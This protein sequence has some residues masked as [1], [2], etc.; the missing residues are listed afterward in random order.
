M[1][2]SVGIGETPDA[3]AYG[4]E[5][6]NTISNTARAVGGLS[7][8]NMAS[9]GLTRIP[10]VKG[11]GPL[12]PDGAVLGAYGRMAPA[13]PGKDT[14]GGHWEL[15]GLVL[16]RPFRTYPGGFP[17]DLIEEFERR[18]GRKTLG[19]VAASGTEIIERLGRGHLRTGSPIVYTSADSVFQVAAHED[20]IPVD[21]LY[22]ICSIAR[23]MLVGE[24]MVGRVIAR[25]FVG[26]PG[27]FERTERRKDFSLVPPQ[28]TVLDAL[29][30]AGVEVT[31]IG[32]IEDIFSGRG[33]TRSS[34]TTNNGAGCRLLEEIIAT[35][36]EG[37]VFA[38]L[39]DFDMVYGHRN[40][41]HGYAR[42]LA[43]FDASLG[44]ML[45][46]LRDTDLL[47]I[48]ADHGCDPTT[49]S[50][51]HSREY[52]PVLA[53]GG[54]VVAGKDVGLRKTFADLGATV[55]ESFG[56]KWDFAGRSFLGEIWAV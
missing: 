25:P 20:V 34:H 48:T 17:A 23:S 49:P 11:V 8:P 4:D 10:G 7:L 28:A 21:E 13:S 24:H 52:V 5:G 1:L 15:M 43:E 30:G 36:G 19:N 39:V 42:A 38:N 46:H 32:K 29:S 40:D 27:R 51:D 35:G 3:H 53:A 12:V 55:A 45:T 41:P 16:D 2:D 50:T 54:R 22:R 33:I 44:R 26:A 9:L 31:G 47:L 6:S 14:M 18:I 56:L 37:L